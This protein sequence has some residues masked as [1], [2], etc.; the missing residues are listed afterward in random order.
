MCLLV[1]F[2]TGNVDF[3]PG[4]FAVTFPAGMT[5]ASFN[6]PITD[7]SMFEGDETFTINIVPG[8]LPRQVQEGPNCT[9]IVT[10]VDDDSKFGDI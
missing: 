4:P 10:I 8:T 6:I 7:D 5:T 3:E 9:V 2:L 1:I